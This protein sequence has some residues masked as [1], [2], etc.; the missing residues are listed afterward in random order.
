MFEE[1]SIV[2]DSCSQP[3]NCISLTNCP[4]CLLDTAGQHQVG[5]PFYP[6]PLQ[7]WTNTPFENA[8]PKEDVPLKNPVGLYGWICPNCRSGLAPWVQRCPCAPLPVQSANA[9]SLTWTW[10]FM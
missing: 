5:C 10:K 7:I 6:R 9:S 1:Y 8:D 4:Y 3:A 2:I